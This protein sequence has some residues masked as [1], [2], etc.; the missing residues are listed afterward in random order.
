MEPW[1]D[2]DGHEYERSKSLPRLGETA[3]RRKVSLFV[4][5]CV[6]QWFQLLF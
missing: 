1:M 5:I 2:T 4:F 3:C 6:H